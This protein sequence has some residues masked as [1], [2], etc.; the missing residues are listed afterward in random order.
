V[1][2]GNF[3]PSFSLESPTSTRDILFLETALPI[4]AFG[5]ARS[6]GIEIGGPVLADRVV[7]QLGFARTLHVLDEGDRSD[8]AGR[9]FGRL[10]WRVLPDQPRTWVTHLGASASLLVAAEEVRFRSRPESHQAPY[11]LDTG[12]LA[13]KDQSATY[14]VEILHIRGPWLFASEALG[15]TT[16]G[17][18]ATSFWGAYA[19]ASRSLTGESHPYDRTQ[20]ILGRYEPARPFSWREREVGAFRLSGRVSYLDLSDRR[21]HGGRETNLTADLTWALNHYLMVK[22]EGGLAVIRGRPDDGELFFAQT[23]LQI[24]FY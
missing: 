19:A 24:D 12:P 11:L 1:K 7:Y 13:A 10:V 20:A 3:T 22:I 18:S 6:S 4:E 8:A 17:E 14:G 21:G 5:P 23:R 15:A 9:V 16:T 2:I